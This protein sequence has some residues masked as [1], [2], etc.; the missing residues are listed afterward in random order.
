MSKLDPAMF[1]NIMIVVGGFSFVLNLAFGL[2]LR[3]LKNWARWTIIVFGILGLL[4][5]VRNFLDPSCSR[6][7]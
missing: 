5:L 7:R 4:G 2:G 6:S 3:E 1:R